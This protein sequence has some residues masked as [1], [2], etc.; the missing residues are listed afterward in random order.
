[1]PD[2]SRCDEQLSP[3]FAAAPSS[4]ASSQVVD[5]NGDGVVDGKEWS[6][7]IGHLRAQRLVF[8]KQRMLVRRC[9]YFGRGLG[10]R[11]AFADPLG[12][13]YDAIRHKPPNRL[14]FH[15]C[16]LLK[17]VGLL[18]HVFLQHTGSPANCPQPFV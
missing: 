4:F 17:V 18:A 8:L 14:V 6:A 12:L 7:F 2:L 13:V 15:S 3:L 10:N 5:E 16:S 11:E 1:M 9:C